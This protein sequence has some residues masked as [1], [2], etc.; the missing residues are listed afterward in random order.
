VIARHGPMLVAAVVLAGAAGHAPSREDVHA[1]ERAHAALLQAQRDAAAHAAA[2]SAEAKRLAAQR[3]TAAARL[4]DSEDATAEAANRLAA[5]VDE[6]RTAEARLDAH[7]RAFAP[8]LPLIERI[9]LY[10]AETLLAVPASPE[11]ALRGITVLGGISRQLEVEAAALRAEE[12]QVAALRERSARESRQLTV[13]EATQARQASVLDMQIAAARAQE[14][15]AND[16]A[17][18]AAQRAAAAAAQADSLRAAIAKIGAEQRAQAEAAGRAADIA[19]NQHHEAAAAAARSQQEALVRPAGSGLAGAV[20]APVA[21][22]IIHGFGDASDSGP[23]R[24]IAYQAPPA[25]HVV[26][27]CSG[28]VV[29]AGPFRSYGQLLIIDCG[30]GF[31]FVLAGLDRIDAAIGRTVSVG[32]PVGVM[33]GWDPRAAGAR[34]SLYLELRQNGEAVNPTPYLHAR[35]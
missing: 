20:T 31:H 7:A 26:S 18:T 16:A 32:E 29:F 27:P 9:S 14:S 19:N 1:A 13:A 28:R 10:P 5:L 15:G 8:L 4:R 11:Q 3:V 6:Q 12:A 2:A 25:A 23:S 21:G 24:G 22:S 17:A 30:G 35:G 33:A 34:P